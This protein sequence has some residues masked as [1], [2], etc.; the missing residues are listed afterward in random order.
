MDGKTEKIF[1]RCLNLISRGYSIQYCFKK[2]SRYKDTL[3]E[4][5]KTIKY[6]KDLKN[7]KPLETNIKSSLEKIYKSAK[8]RTKPD[9]YISKNKTSVPYSGR[10]TFLLKPAFVFTTVLVVLIF[11]FAGT[12]YASQDSLPGEN[13]YVVKRA[14]ENVQLFFYPESKKGQLHFKLLNNRIYEADRLIKTGK[15]GYIELIEE[16]LIEIDEEYSQCKK[17]KFFEAV[18]EEETITAINK[19]KNRYRNKYR[20]YNQ[21]LEESNGYNNNTGTNIFQYI[22]IDTNPLYIISDI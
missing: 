9:K 22:V 20:Q 10:R 6:L 13:L 12:V 7:I 21:D 11:S 2:Y 14:S 5:F 18:D 15:D 17:Y 19:I 3:E 1:N 4:Y 16:L 8:D